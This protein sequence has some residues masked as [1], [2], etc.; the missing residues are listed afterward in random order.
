MLCAFKLIETVW[1][2]IR[3]AIRKS[4]EWFGGWTP[5]C[6]DDDVFFDGANCSA[7]AN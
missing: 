5:K 7:G 6:E 4:D 2:E 1:N 3:S